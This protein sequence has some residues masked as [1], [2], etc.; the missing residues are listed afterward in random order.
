ME[1]EERVSPSSV[2]PGGVAPASGGEQQSGIMDGTGGAHLG[3]HKLEAQMDAVHLAACLA[4]TTA[5]DASRVAA[6]VGRRCKLDPGLKAP[7]GFKV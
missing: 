3:Q 6:A 5:A 1:V 4:E 2:L 7:P